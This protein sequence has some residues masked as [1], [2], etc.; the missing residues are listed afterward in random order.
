[1]LREVIR[2]S[3]QSGIHAR[4]A[5]VL[6][7]ACAQYQSRI[8]MVYNGKTI[9]GK[10]IMSILGAG[11]KGKASLELICSGS[12]EQEAMAQ[13]KQLFAEGFGFD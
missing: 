4:P 6:A 5:G 12:D 9:K 11:I 10:S 1:M 3:N 8:E 7:K 13:L 2:V